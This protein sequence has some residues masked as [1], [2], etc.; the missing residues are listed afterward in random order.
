MIEQYTIFSIDDTRKENKEHIR[1][2]L[3]L[4]EVM[5][6][7]VNGNDHAALEAAK[8]KWN[9]NITSPFKRGEYGIWYSTLNALE[10]AAAHGD[11]LTFEDDAILT[12]GF[13]QLLESYLV[14]LPRSVDF[15]SL[16][17]PQNQQHDFMYDISYNNGG[18]PFW[19]G[20]VRGESKFEVGHPYLCRIYQTYSCVAQIYTKRGAQK[21]LNRARITG[22]NQ[23]I[24]CWLMAQAHG[25]YINGYA[26]KP[27]Y[28]NLI[29]YNWDNETTI[30]KTEWILL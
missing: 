8:E 7:C 11:L 6:D 9:I 5:L 12:L 21:M 18:V 19:P 3:S 27:Q 30:H 15:I 13:Q 2:S 4:K 22:I 24:D 14:D 1:A 23:P 20:Q 26:P 29:D 28:C 10:Y 16:F 17:V 25:G